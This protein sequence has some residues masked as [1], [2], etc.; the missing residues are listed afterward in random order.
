MKTVV[1]K[2]SKGNGR[3]TNARS[4]AG[5]TF[6]RFRISSAGGLGAYGEAA[7]GEVAL[8]VAAIPTQVGGFK[9][10]AGTMAAK[11]LPGSCR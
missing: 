7:D 2:V 4:V 3:V 5:P 8:T 6:A 1:D 9:C 11:Y 10:A